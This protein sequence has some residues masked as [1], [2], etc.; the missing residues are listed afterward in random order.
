MMCRK[1]YVYL[2]LLSLI[3][4]LAPPGLVAAA[5]LQGLV[6]ALEGRLAELGRGTIHYKYYKFKC[7]PDVFRKIKHAFDQ[8]AAGVS[9]KA[10][11][12]RIRALLYGPSIDRMTAYRGTIY[13][14][15]QGKQWRFVKKSI[16]EYGH[17][18]EKLEKRAAKR[19]HGKKVKVILPTVD[20]DV[21]DDGKTLLRLENNKTLIKSGISL[22]LNYPTIMS[23]D[24]SLAPW[25]MALE[26]P[27]LANQTITVKAQ[28]SI[29]SISY[30]DRLTGGRITNVVNQNMVSEF[31]AAKGFAPV[32]I[33]GTDNNKTTFE[34]LFHCHR[35]RGNEYIVDSVLTCHYPAAKHTKFSGEVYLIN[36]WSNKVAEKDLKVKLPKTYLLI[37]ERFGEASP[38]FKNIDG[39]K[40]TRPAGVPGGGR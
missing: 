14:K 21:S 15:A 7:T 8:N 5:D 37:D 17:N 9:G 40:S 26:S 23:L 10:R 20:E 2:L 16:E 32:R 19:L 6:H 28:G 31:D 3:T 33:Y 36:S 38:I 11:N 27:P 13:Y 34:T 18:I 30:L 35:A 24:I 1:F 39:N 22:G 12:D 4:T 29:W 25:Y